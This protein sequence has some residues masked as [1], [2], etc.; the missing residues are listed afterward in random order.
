[1]KPGSVPVT[2]LLYS[3]VQAELMINEN[4]TGTIEIELSPLGSVILELQK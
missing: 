1:L 3:N 4:G 2:D